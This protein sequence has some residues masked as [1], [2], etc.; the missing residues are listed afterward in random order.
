[1]ATKVNYVKLY[2]D[3]WSQGEL[4]KTTD[5]IGMDATKVNIE[6][7]ADGNP[8]P[9]AIEVQ[10]RTREP[11]NKQGG[12]ATIKPVKLMIPRASQHSKWYLRN[13]AI[14]ELGSFMGEG[15]SFNEVATVVRT[16][17]TS[18]QYFRQGLG[19]KWAIRGTAVQRP[20]GGSDKGNEAKEQPHALKL[21]L[22]GG[23][24]V[25]E[26]SVVQKPGLQLNPVKTKT[27]AFIRSPADIFYY[28]GHA[29]GG[30]L[31]DHPTYDIWLTPDT[32]LKSWKTGK[33]LS[34]SPMD[35]DA[36]IIAGC[37][38]MHID[39]VKKKGSGLEWAK[40]LCTKEGPLRV[41]LGNYDTTPLDS[42]GGNTLAAQM[43]AK[44]AKG[45][46]YDKY[47]AAWFAANKTAG[48]KVGCG[49]DQAGYWY[50]DPKTGGT[51]GPYPI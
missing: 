24:E 19:A 35:I 7:E 46:D 5:I 34:N 47:V 38:I 33:T 22:S 29:L 27:W 25:L 30:N 10:V 31:V 51:N 1:M 20:T 2:R 15:D 39:P 26:V 37:S 21:F 16:A 6:V 32:L 8:M 4:T 11:G 3:V 9:D 13:V 42:Q 45:L 40:L 36:L 23:V 12:K 49:V 28:S 44:I 50:M 17:G 48:I 18:D 43:A 41:I 14:S